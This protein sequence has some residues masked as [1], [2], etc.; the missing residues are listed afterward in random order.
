M[1]ALPVLPNPIPA[2]MKGLN[3]AEI[4]DQNF[5]EYVQQ[6]NGRIEAKPSPNEP[7]IDGSA[8]TAADFIALFESQLISRHLDL[9]ARKYFIPLVRRA[10]RAM[11]WWRD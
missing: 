6:W 2:R 5:I 7:I 11:R 9:M 1:S 3:R 4:C 10:M 8:C